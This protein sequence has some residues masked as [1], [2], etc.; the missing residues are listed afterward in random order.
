MG[1]GRRCEE[2]GCRRNDRGHTAGVAEERLRGCCGL[3][4]LIV[5]SEESS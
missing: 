1:G 4:R 2:K 3:G 5:N